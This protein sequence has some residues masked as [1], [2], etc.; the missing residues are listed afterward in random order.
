MDKD[1]AKW[2]SAEDY[3]GNHVNLLRYW[4]VAIFGGVVD[5]RQA[6]ARDPIIAATRHG[7]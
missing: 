1:N 3:Q 6:M 7:G 4:L 5:F 2:L